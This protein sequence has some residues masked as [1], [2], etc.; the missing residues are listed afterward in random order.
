[1]KEIARVY[2]SSNGKEFLIYDG[3]DN[4]L[5]VKDVRDTTNVIETMG[6]VVLDSV[7]SE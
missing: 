1:V 5:S 3:N 4:L 7:E 2:L 6:N